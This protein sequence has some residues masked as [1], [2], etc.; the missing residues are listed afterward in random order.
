MQLTPYQKRTWVEVNLDAIRHNYLEVKKIV[1]KDVKVCC[2]IKANA[3]SHG[4]IQLAKLYE[5]MGADFLAVSNIEEAL[6]LRGA[7]VKIPVLILG[8][9]DCACAR[10]LA[11]NNFSQC[12]FS[13]EYAQALSLSAKKAGVSIKAHFKLD[14]GMGRIGFRS[15]EKEELLQ[16]CCYETLITEGIFTHFAS[17]DEGKDGQE[18]TK[19]QYRLFRETIEYLEEKGIRFSIKHCANSAAIL[20]YPEFHLDMVR[21][22][23]ILYGEFPSAQIESK[24]K[25]YP[26]FKLKTIVSHLKTIKKGEC[27]SYG[28]K[29]KAND[30]RIIATI[31]IGYADGLHQYN[32][33]GGEV[34]VN[35]KRAPIVGRICM[36][37]CM[38]DVT[39]IDVSLGMEVT[40]YGG[41][42]TVNEVAKRNDMIAYEILCSIGKRLPISYISKGNIESVSDGI[43]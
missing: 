30:D 23:I 8:Y 19:N 37:Q 16:S 42:I 5:K 15:E 20:D 43:L 10:I 34:E 32:S 38:I 24:R 35:G 9:T 28:R 18:Y 13:M 40:V 21:A 7:G 27:V 1:G 25:F 14:T 11:D 22:G 12:V 41:Q 31:P 33:C 17:A 39:G 4:A 6:Q 29:Y 26:A 3:Y 2:V 36:D